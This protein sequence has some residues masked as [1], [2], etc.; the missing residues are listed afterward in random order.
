M[1]QR[2]Q[3]KTDN[4]LHKKWFSLYDYERRQRRRK[5]RV[6]RVRKGVSRR[7][8]E[9][10][11]EWGGIKNATHIRLRLRGASQGDARKDEQDEDEEDEENK[12]ATCRRILWFYLGL[13]TQLVASMPNQLACKRQL[14]RSLPPS[15]T[16]SRTHSFTRSLPLCRCY[17]RRDEGV[18]SA[19]EK[20]FLPRL[21]PKE[22][23]R[24]STD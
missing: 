11:R 17:L 12:S 8:E 9:C 5:G 14:C 3:Q 18:S 16:H 20:E 13:F 6:R 24:V 21:A 23:Y 10:V 2:Q 15:L 7:R 19:A 4:K 22:V 1:Q